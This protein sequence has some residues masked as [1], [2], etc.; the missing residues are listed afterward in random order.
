MKRKLKET[1]SSDEVESINKK[2]KNEGK[3]THNIHFK[4]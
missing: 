1:E 3:E 4:S 2:S